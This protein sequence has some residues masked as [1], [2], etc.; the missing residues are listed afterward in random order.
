MNK[1][2]SSDPSVVVVRD[3]IYL[4]HFT[5]E[6]L[7]IVVIRIATVR[8]RA[9]ATAG[10]VYS[11]TATGTYTWGTLRRVYDTAADTSEVI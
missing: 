6:R 3:P 9:A 7:P 5:M 4:S 11:D 1:T 2:V 10:H 8:V